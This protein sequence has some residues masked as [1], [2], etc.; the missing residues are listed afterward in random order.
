MVKKILKEN[1]T[2][3]EFINFI[4]ENDIILEFIIWTN[5]KKE[6][7]MSKRRLKKWKELK[8]L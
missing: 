6:E 5:I 2:K 4:A 3:K 1:Y 8:I 7:K